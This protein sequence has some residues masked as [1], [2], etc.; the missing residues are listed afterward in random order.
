MLCNAALMVLLSNFYSSFKLNF[1]FEF[2]VV[3]E[4]NHSTFE[5]PL[6]LIH[7][8]NK[9]AAWL[10][11]YA[12]GITSKQNALGKYVIYELCLSSVVFLMQNTD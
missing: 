6:Y 5:G 3:R 11:R 7:I 1:L 2:Q 4:S 9:L 12:K 10:I 8:Y